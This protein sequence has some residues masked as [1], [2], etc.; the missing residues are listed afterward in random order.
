MQKRGIRAILESDPEGRGDVALE[1]EIRRTI[2]WIR[3]C[4]DRINEL[5]D[6]VI[7]TVSDEATDHDLA[8]VLGGLGLSE[9]EVTSGE[10]RDMS[11]NLVREKWSSGVNVWEEKLRWNRAH[12]A[13]L[14][15]Q[16]IA[17]GFE[18]K[19]L[20]I[21]SRTL[22]VLE[23]AINGI[24]RDLGHNPR[25]AEVRRFIRARLEQASQPRELTA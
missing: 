1:M 19:R 24:V 25:D 6:D 16:W 21:M 18:Q 20:E 7:E 17:A 3:F 8:D 12:L 13:T 5:A 4:E 23:T 14:T 15:K 9:R 22:D 11:T 2:G 10:E